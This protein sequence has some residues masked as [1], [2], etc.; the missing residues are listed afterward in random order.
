MP[1]ALCYVGLVVALVLLLVFGLDL[2]TGFILDKAFPFGGV[3]LLMDV[4]FVLGAA[5]LAY[6]SW[7][8]LREQV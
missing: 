6:L 7:A 4:G 8:T 1:K 5:V 2:A 3:S